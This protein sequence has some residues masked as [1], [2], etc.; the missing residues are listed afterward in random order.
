MIR[1]TNISDY[2]K[3]NP[4]QD[5]YINPSILEL[6]GHAFKF[7]HT[8]KRKTWY[9]TVIEEKINNVLISIPDNIFQLEFSKQRIIP[10]TSTIDCSFYK[11]IEGVCLVSGET[12]ENDGI[13]HKL[14]RLPSIKLL[15]N[16]GVMENVSFRSN[17]ELTHYLDHLNKSGLFN[18]KDVFQVEDSRELVSN[19]YEYLINLVENGK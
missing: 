18:S 9:G 4:L 1:L 14:Y 17:K 12:I 7:V 16:D 15:N 13:T 2:S 10:D 11:N 3:K 6:Q 5:I 8:I 19:I